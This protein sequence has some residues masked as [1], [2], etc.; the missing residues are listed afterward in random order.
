MADALKMKKLIWDC[1]KKSRVLPNESWHHRARAAS[2]AYRPSR[3]LAKQEKRLETI[4][5]GGVRD[6]RMGV[7]RQSPSPQLLPEPGLKLPLSKTSIDPEHSSQHGVQRRSHF[8]VSPLNFDWRQS[9]SRTTAALL[10]D[11]PG[12]CPFSVQQKLRPDRDEHPCGDWNHQ[13]F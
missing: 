2:D 12:R 3:W 8:R 13:L 10:I 1:H 11:L 5:R 7:R 4:C 9:H 6:T